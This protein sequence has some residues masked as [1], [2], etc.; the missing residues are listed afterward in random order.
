VELEVVNIAIL[1]RVPNT[2][3]NIIA[4]MIAANIAPIP[5]RILFL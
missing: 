5:K 2:V 1:V 3:P 4:T